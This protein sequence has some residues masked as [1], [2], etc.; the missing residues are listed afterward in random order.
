MK[1]YVISSVLTFLSAF[2]TSLGTGVLVLDVDNLK[3]SLTALLVSAAATGARAL[4]KYLN[5]KFVLN[6]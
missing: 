4:L 2:L 1:R 5:E 6:Q 3:L